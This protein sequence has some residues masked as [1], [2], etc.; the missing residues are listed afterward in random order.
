MEETNSPALLILLRGDFQI[1]N[2]YIKF[3]HST[4]LVIYLSNDSKQNLKR[5]LEQSSLE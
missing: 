2:Y 5:S 3:F 4:S 1:D